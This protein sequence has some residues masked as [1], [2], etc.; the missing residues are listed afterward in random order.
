MRRECDLDSRNK[1]K[2]AKG[3]IAGEGKR[4]K[5]RLEETPERSLMKAWW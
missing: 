4:L 3:K 1:G 5:A 2:K